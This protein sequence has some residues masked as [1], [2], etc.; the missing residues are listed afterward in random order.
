MRCCW[1]ST[2]GA[3]DWKITA[4][5]PLSLASVIALVSRQFVVVVIAVATG[6]VANIVGAVKLR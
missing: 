6:I 4:A 3:L 2:N 1:P 5:T